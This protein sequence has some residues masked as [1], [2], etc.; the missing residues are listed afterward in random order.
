MPKMRVTYHIILMTLLVFMPI[1]KAYA[2]NTKAIYNELKAINNQQ[3]LFF[4]HNKLNLSGIT[5][6]SLLADLGIRKQSTLSNNE[7]AH[8]DETDEKL[9]L[10]LY[11]ISSLSHGNQ[12]TIATNKFSYFKDAL[13]NNTLALYIDSAMPQFNAVVRLRES[14]N[15]FKHI[16]QVYWPTL[17]PSFNPKL[18]QGHQQV[19]NLRH[20][21][22][23]LGDM[24]DTSTSKFRTHIFDTAMRNSLKQFQQRHGL[25]PSGT[26]DTET[27][28]ALNTTID[29]RIEKLQINLWR[30]LS[31]PRTPPSKYIIVNIPSYRLKVIDK[32]KQTLNM[33]VIVGKPEN[34]TPIMVTAVSSVT[35][36]PTWTPTQNIINNDLLPLHHRN[37]NALKQSNFYLAQ[38]YGASTS[39]TDIP[40]N[41][42]AMLKTYRLVQIP[43]LNNALGT[44]RFNIINNNAIYLHDTPTK[45][46][47]NRKQRALSHGCI[48]LGNADKLLHT[49]I[50]ENKSLKS[51]LKQIDG[52]TRSIRLPESVPVFI[53]Y[54][55]AFVDIKSQIHWRN[56]LYQKDR[57]HNFLTKKIN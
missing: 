21:L 15:K 5:L 19:K 23:I 51:Q 53:T 10:A 57:K 27:R 46:L 7:R 12:L 49:L 47:F 6:L 18:G 43:G 8:I 41:L 17:P 42:N 39:Y 38:G 45:S 52:K 24:S 44:V 48:R 25:T 29:T 40:Y 31:L 32:G 37:R 26:I 1:T 50:E 14:I 55:T 4:N 30:W 9:T 13:H 3:P 2:I 35:V 22:V 28:N 56:D 20:K 16:R 33:K 11:H 36:N 54:Q 34:Q